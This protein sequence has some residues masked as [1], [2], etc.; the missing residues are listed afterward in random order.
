MM[1][2][3]YEVCQELSRDDW[4]VLYRGR[5][6]KDGSSVLLKMPR[7]N[8]VSPF[9]VRLLVHEYELLRGLSPAG[10]VRVHELLRDDR[11]C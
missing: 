11:G 6:R 9:A 10:V 5:C 2:P 8:S 1:V 3:D 7:S 4:F